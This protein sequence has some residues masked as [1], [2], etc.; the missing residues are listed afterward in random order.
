MARILVL[1]GT[2]DGQ[3]AL[4]AHTMADELRGSGHSVDV[5][6]AR[7]L[8]SS[9]SARVF[10]GVIVGASVRW[11]RHQRA[12]RD[13]ARANAGILARK[14]AWFYSVSLAAV[15]PGAGR[16]HAA[17]L[18][19]AF[20]DE[21]GWVPERAEVFGGALRYG[22]YGP[23]LRLAMKLVARFARLNPD[24]SRDHDYTD[25]AAVQ[26]FAR[27]HGERVEPSVPEAARRAE[28]QPV[29]LTDGEAARADAEDEPETLRTIP[30]HHA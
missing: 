27:A 24:T 3:T 2:D 28:L 8:P 20:I 15:D 29:R 16:E 1:Y 26:A 13:F 4:I 11:G 19:T 21:T 22:S 6:D 23:L 25:W 9:F 10:D 30:L 17:A 14:P 5:R 18:L 12:V 7:A